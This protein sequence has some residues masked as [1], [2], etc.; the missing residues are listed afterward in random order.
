MRGLFKAIKWRKEVTKQNTKILKDK[1][2]TKKKILLL[3]DKKKSQ[4]KIR[5]HLKRR[6]QKKMIVLEIENIKE[7]NTK[8]SK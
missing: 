3:E 5:G 4:P 1:W 8:K 7:K 2:T 6:N